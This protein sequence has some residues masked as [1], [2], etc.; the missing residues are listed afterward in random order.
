MTP[1]FHP[2]VDSQGNIC[3]NILKSSDWN[4]KYDVQAILLAIQ[5]LMGEPGIDSPLNLEAANLWSNKEGI[6]LN[7]PLFRISTSCNLKD[8]RN[9]SDT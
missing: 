8:T 4:A 1:I 7:N 2:N 5:Y 3:L 9:T 6:T